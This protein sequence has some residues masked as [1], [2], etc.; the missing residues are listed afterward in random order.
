MQEKLGKHAS[1]R[2]AGVILGQTICMMYFTG[3]QVKR[4]ACTYYTEFQ[5]K[6]LSFYITGVQ[7][8]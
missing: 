5:V 1:C 6:L 4:L 3:V 8:K 2:V 7:L